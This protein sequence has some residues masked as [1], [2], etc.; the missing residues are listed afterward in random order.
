MCTHACF[1][2]INAAQNKIMVRSFLKIL[3]ISRRMSPSQLPMKLK[4]AAIYRCSFI[5]LRLR[6]SFM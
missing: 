4:S 3:E 6:L 2:K 1:I 5:R